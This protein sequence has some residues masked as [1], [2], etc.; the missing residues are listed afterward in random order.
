M[1][2]VYVFGHKNP[3]TDSVCSAIA[4]AYLKNSIGVCS[5]PKVIGAI[6]RESKFVLDYFGVDTPSY[7]NDVKIQIK[8]LK[9]VKK[10]VCETADSIIETSISLIIFSS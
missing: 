5:I 2:N 9:Y 1:K 10:V 6:N 8:D 3:D 7:L 4:L